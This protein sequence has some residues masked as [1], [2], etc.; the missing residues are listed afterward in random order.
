MYLISIHSIAMSLSNVIA[1]ELNFDN[2]KRAKISYGLEVIIGAI[3]KFIVFIIVFLGFGVLKQSL[4]AMFTT[5]F[6][7]YVSGGSH[8]KTF[9]GC[10][11]FSNV[12]YISIGILAKVI[13]IN[14]YL[15][16]ILNIISF[17]IVL[18]KSPVDPPEKPIK[19]DQ[20]RYVMKFISILIL[21]LYIYISSLTTENDVK[22]SVALAMY[23]Q[24]LTLTSWEKTFYK[25]INQLNLKAKEVN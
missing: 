3:I 2:V 12:I 21:L 4:I 10:L 14:N 20:K 6:M 19:T 22:N 13:I 1:Q 18:L 5:V 17:L 23:F 25:Y 8:C 24:V 11:I 7:R 15:F 9:I 16:Y